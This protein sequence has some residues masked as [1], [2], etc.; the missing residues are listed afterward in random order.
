[1]PGKILHQNNIHLTPDLYVVMTIHYCI[2]INN[3]KKLTY[4]LCGKLF[5]AMKFI[6]MMKSSNDDERL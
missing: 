6:T 2:L 4:L 1:M 3:C 5:D